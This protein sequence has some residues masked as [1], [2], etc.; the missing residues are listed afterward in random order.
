MPGTASRTERG[1]ARRVPA[2]A[3]STTWR[4]IPAEDRADERRENGR[5][6]A[7]D[8]DHRVEADGQSRQHAGPENSSCRCRRPVLRSAAAMAEKSSPYATTFASIP[9]TSH[10]PLRLPKRREGEEN[11]RRPQR[12]PTGRHEHV[13]E[14][15]PTDRQNPQSHQ[16][17][18]DGRRLQREPPRQPGRTS[19][20]RRGAR[21]TTRGTGRG[22]TT[23]GSSSASPCRGSA[24]RWGRGWDSGRTSRA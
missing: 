9:P 6:D 17:A 23:R 18:D 19:G 2:P 16:P 21:S 7:P 22:R 11:P 4:S 1:G 10:S 24:A 14:G 5:R 15:H 13:D 8:A 20:R 12:R 3:D